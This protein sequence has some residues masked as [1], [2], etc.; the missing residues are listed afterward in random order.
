[1]GTAITMQTYGQKEAEA[2]ALFQTISRSLSALDQDNLSW[3]CAGSDVYN[4]NKKGT[5]EV[6]PVTAKC[7]QDCIS[8]SKASH[9]AFDLTIG[10]V[11][12]LWNIDTDNARVPSKEELADALPYVNS[13]TVSAKGNTV[14]LAEG[15]FLDLGA[16]GKGLACDIAYDLLKE[17]S[18]TGATVA[19]AGSVLVYGTNPNHKDGLW[20]VGIRNPFSDNQN[21]C[22]LTLSLREGFLSTSG[23][24]EKILEQDGV[25]YHHILSPK[26][27]M[28]AESNVTSVTV[29]APSGALADA[30]STACYVLGYGEEAMSLLA[31]YEA[32]AVFIE[33]DGTIH[34]TKSI[35]SSLQ[36]VDQTSMVS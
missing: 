17:S 19:V 7:I 16:V 22:I 8:L 27:G 2:K 29:L 18:V 20:S 6:S 33:K 23:D 36:T 14:S 31:K 9:G 25:T 4:I 30:L 5:A 32:D 15:Q 13:N 34:A 10:K 35:E 21:D 3:R 28:P 1:M 12:T 26:T 11:T 24:Y